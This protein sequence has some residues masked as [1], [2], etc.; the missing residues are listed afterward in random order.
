MGEGRGK[1]WPQ[2]NNPT[3]ARLEVKVRRKE[4]QELTSGLSCDHQESLAFASAPPTARR[5]ESD[6][7]G[8]QSPARGA[9]CVTTASAFAA[10]ATRRQGCA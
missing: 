4:K 10:S 1:R 8:T 9:R 5:S 3:A 6:A 7:G 2:E